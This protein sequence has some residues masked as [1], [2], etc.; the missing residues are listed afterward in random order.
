[1]GS[2]HSL[3][4]A[5]K[6]ARA[7]RRAEAD[8]AALRAARAA[9]PAGD[10]G[11]RGAMA[12]RGVTAAEAALAASEAA[13]LA[14]FAG[15]GGGP[16]AYTREG[17]ALVDALPLVALA[18]FAPE[19]AHCRLLCN[20]TLEIRDEGAIAWVLC[21]A[22]E[23]QC[24]TLAARRAAVAELRN[25]DVA[26]ARA[27]AL[28][29]AHPGAVAVV[30]GAARA[31]AR[32]D[33]SE[34]ASGA[35]AAAAALA[36]AARTAA[37]AGSTKASLEVVRAT[38]TVARAMADFGD[39]RDGRAELLASGAAPALVALA[40]GIV[41]KGSAGAAEQVAKAMASL[42]D[43]EDGQAELL[44][45]GAAPALVALAGEGVVKGDDGAAQYVAMAVS[46]VAS[47]AEGRAAL[48]DAGAGAALAALA[49]ADLGAEAAEQVARAVASLG[50]GAVDASGAA[51]VA[52]D[53][54][55]HTA[56]A[57]AERS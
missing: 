40:G 36:A 45:S 8:R 16:C 49:R 57:A 56:S 20:E 48:V 7:Y 52:A 19:V 32:A 10:G 50:G 15:R 24:C 21:A 12:R 39:Y 18:G 9:I 51:I 30:A 1:M 13:A 5:E 44:A 33:I 6:E 35:A 31:L 23:A 38:N 53:A 37:V 14:A 26:P 47:G 28:M 22:A 4:A 34:E 54:G 46:C 29:R 55:D 42:G 43:S 17:E 25:P 11:L 41:V 3:P 27:A 2:A